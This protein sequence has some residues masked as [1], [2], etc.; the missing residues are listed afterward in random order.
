MSTNEEHTQAITEAYNAK[1]RETTSAA[2]ARKVAEAFG[3]MKEELDSIP[4]ASN[5]GLSCGNPVAAASLKE[6]EH[7][8]DL[9]SGG[10]IDVFLAA[11]KVGP[12]GQVVGLDNSADM[13]TLARK[14]AAG[15]NLR[16]PHVSFVQASL[17][18]EL[19]IT[20]D[21]V[22]CILSNCVI[23]L[24]PF[25]G[26]AT[27]MKEA[28]RVLRPG[29]RITLDDVISKTP[30]PDAILKDLSAHVNCIA[31]AVTPEE[32]RKFLEEA[33]FK[34]LSTRDIVFVETKKDLNVYYEAGTNCGSAGNNCCGP[35][36][37]GRDLSTK[38][39]YNVNEYVASYQVY[40]IKPGVSTTQ[41]PDVLLHSWD[42]FPKVKSSPPRLTPDE[43]VSLIRDPTKLSDNYTVID[44]RRNDHSG[45]H[46]R[47]SHQCPAQT[48][49][50][51]LPG[52]FD[53]FKTS[54]K[55]IFY[56]GSSNGRGP[57][58]AG[59]YQDY[60]DAVGAEHKS[61]AYV[62]EGGVKEWLTRF[63]GEEDLVDYD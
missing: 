55:V 5:M 15:R 37:T 32:Y 23:N 58:C 44:V 11:S 29:G 28:Y 61:Q 19:P 36:E 1:A 40:A 4:E 22:D 34:G 2:S 56:C 47:G 48:F 31:G 54:K 42:A 9:G 52:F 8:L 25:A 6:G 18:Q 49:Y 50:D 14:N 16:S 45:G 12:T 10:G 33:G 59:W 26:K 30:L 57:R 17:T 60:L 41:A 39:N 24:L 63:T 13:V 62:L 51:E 3:Y 21:S 20:S 46:V 53:K 35:S 7:V 27:V 38:P 43:V